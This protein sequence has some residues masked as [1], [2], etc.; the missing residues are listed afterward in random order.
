MG[1]TGL[2]HDMKHESPT[3]RY[4]GML[5]AFALCCGAV[6]ATVL[7]VLII[8]FE[9]LGAGPTSTALIS[10]W[11]GLTMWLWTGVFITAHDAMHGLVLPHNDRVNYLVGKFCMSIYA[12]LPYDRMLAAHHVHHQHPSEPEDPDYWPLHWPASIHASLQPIG[13]FLGFMRNYLSWKP[14]LYFAVIFESLH[15]FAGIEK[16]VMVMMWICPVVLSTI[17][18]FI[19]GTWLPHRPGLA[20]EGSGPRKAR[21]NNYPEWVSFLTCFHFGYHY[22]HHDRP[23]IPWWSLP[24]ARKERLRRQ[25]LVSLA[26][27]KT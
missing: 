23:N 1:E 21:S 4:Q 22:E 7:G 26:I 8:N 19:F 17:Q 12:M 13:W 16:S 25:N 5:I 14:V 6:G 10:G 20:F 11:I 3:W 18:L 15:A 2:E 27:G 9:Q 24:R